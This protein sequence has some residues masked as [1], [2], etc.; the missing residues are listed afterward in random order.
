MITIP[1]L[2]NPQL[3]L[4][5]LQVQKHNLLPI[6]ALAAVTRT[7]QALSSH[8]TDC[9]RV[10]T[11]LSSVSVGR[12]SA[13]M[14]TAVADFRAQQMNRKVVLQALLDRKTKLVNGLERLSD[15]TAEVV[16]RL[17]KVVFG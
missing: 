16:K 3:Q 13:P 10:D 12:Y 15:R 5:F 4:C 6:S 11:N 9:G 14:L 7:S 2:I 1:C 8:L 17:S